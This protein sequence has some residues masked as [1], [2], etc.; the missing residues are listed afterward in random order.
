MTE[1]NENQGGRQ[2]QDPQIYNVKKDLTGWK[3]NRRKFL[4]AAAT[5]ATAATAAAM[6]AMDES[7]E[8]TSKTAAGLGASIALGMSIPVM[9]AVR[10]GESFA[11]VWQFTN[12]SDT[13][14]SQEVRLELMSGDQLQAPASILVP[15]LAPGETVAVE[16]DM[17]APSEP[18]TYQGTWCLRVAD[19][20]DPVASGPF[21]ILLGCIVESPHPYPNNMNETW[22]VTN[23]D[24]SAGSTEVH[25]SRVELG[26]GY[27]YD[28]IILRDEA[29]Q[30][31]QIIGDN[32][33][34]GL[35]SDQVPG[36]I[37]QVQLITS[38]VAQYWGFCLDQVGSPHVAYLPIIFK[39][40]TA[41]PSPTPCSC[42]GH[43]SC[44]PH[45]TC[46]TVH[47]WYPC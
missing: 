13:A 5:A 26:S 39:Q 47:Y 40:P 11:H 14:L 36:R 17:L 25:F 43:C 12:E 22:I 10:P 35:W 32:Y 38:S 2:E 42:Y 23:P 3:F 31:V 44:N 16:A 29:G 24:T 28:Y 15:E 1:N 37:V 20:T 19:G 45:C 27:P 18:G 7:G 41:T 21:V 33:P 9:Q 6:A 34:S 30:Q 8:A 46:D 4:T